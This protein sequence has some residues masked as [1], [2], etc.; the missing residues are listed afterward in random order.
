LEGFKGAE[1]ISG[2]EI[3]TLPVDVLVPAATEDVINSRNAEKIQAKLIVEGANGPTSSKADGIIN[4]KGITVAPDIL[5]N[6]G[7]VTVSYFEWVQNRLGY[8]WTAERVNRR[9]DRIMKDAFDHVFKTSQDYKVPLRI[10]AYMV[11][12]DKVAK[13]YKYRGGY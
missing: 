3:L 11:A 12:I 8:K 2:E 13:T 1:R 4:E 5:A 10:A 9:S 7:G 6:A